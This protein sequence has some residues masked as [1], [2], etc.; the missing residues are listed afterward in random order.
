MNEN[1]E[2]SMKIKG[3][4]F[5]ITSLILLNITAYDDTI[6]L[7]DSYGNISISPTRLPNTLIKYPTHI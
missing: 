4:A 6:P 7:K 2:A 3:V 1:I 5:L